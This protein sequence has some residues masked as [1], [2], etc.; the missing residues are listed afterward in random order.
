VLALT[1]LRPPLRGQWPTPGV[2][3][4]EISVDGRLYRR[5]VWRQA[6]PNTVEQYREA[7]PRDSRHLRVLRDGTW[8]I[9][10]LDSANPDGP[11]GSPVQHFFVDHPIGRALGALSPYLLAALLWY[12]V[13]R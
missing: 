10:H 13:G 7:I 6:Y 1:H 8:V 11:N 12:K 2:F 5:A 3:P 4:D 9:E